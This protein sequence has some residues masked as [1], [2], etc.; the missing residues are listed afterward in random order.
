MSVQ[1]SNFTCLGFV[2]TRPHFLQSLFCY[3]RL[4]E[5]L[6]LFPRNLWIGDI[7]F[8]TEPVGGPGLDGASKGAMIWTSWERKPLSLGLSSLEM[9]AQGKGWA[10]GQP[11]VQSGMDLSKP[12]FLC[13]WLDSMTFR[14]ESSL[15]HRT[16]F[17]CKDILADIPKCPHSHTGQSPVQIKIL[18]S[19]REAFITSLQQQSV[20][21]STI[22]LSSPLWEQS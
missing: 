15:L 18:L 20:H 13:H 6:A 5:G 2:P 10:F 21:P 14:D 7:R 22:F 9:E 8:W 3:T 16:C 1:V 11:W 12:W 17:E 19:E 4:L